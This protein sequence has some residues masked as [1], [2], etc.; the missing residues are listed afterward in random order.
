MYYHYSHAY[1]CH[2]IRKFLSYRSEKFTTKNGN[3]RLCQR[4][5]TASVEINLKNFTEKLQRAARR[6]TYRII[7]SALP[8]V[9]LMYGRRAI[10]MQIKEPSS[11]SFV[12]FAL[13]FP[14]F[15]LVFRTVLPRLRTRDWV[16][17]RVVCLIFH[18]LSSRSSLCCNFGCLVR[19][20]Y[21]FFPLSLL[22]TLASV[23]YFP[24]PC[25]GNIEKWELHTTNK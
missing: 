25:F 9:K 16:N 14:S 17:T 23:L 10:F 1:Q 3:I 20:I 12:P 2:L 22:F 5:Q 15:L 18:S 21:L 4:W 24:Y 6:V 19:R 13:L 7:F 8:E 11:H